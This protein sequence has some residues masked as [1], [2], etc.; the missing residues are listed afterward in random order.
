MHFR[1]FRPPS[2]HGGRARASH[3]RPS[4]RKRPLLLEAVFL[5]TKN[6]L[7]LPNTYMYQIH[8]AAPASSSSRPQPIGGARP[9]AAAASEAAWRPGRGRAAGHRAV[10]EEGRDRARH[11]P[12]RPSRRRCVGRGQRRGDQ[13]RRGDRR[14]V[15]P[16]RPLRTTVQK[17]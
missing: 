6:I 7:A 9:C 13:R 10:R 4:V 17:S 2:A 1:E 14:P 3:L 16:T 5:Q 8:Q 11:G 15:P 12:P